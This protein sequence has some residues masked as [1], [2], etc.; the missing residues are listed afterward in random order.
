L[1]S[2]ARYFLIVLLREA[3]PRSKLIAAL[4]ALSLH[5]FSVSFANTVPDTIANA[6]GSDVTAR[7]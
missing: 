1:Q 6:L 4:E 5:P 2:L 3:L 7:T